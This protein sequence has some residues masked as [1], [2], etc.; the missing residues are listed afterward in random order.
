M[1]HNYRVTLTA[2]ED[3]QQLSIPSPD[4]VEISVAA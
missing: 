3:A 1:A 2:G 4:I